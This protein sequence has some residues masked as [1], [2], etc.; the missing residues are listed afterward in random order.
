MKKLKS[1]LAL[2]IAMVIMCI[3]VCSACAV[4]S[5]ED[6]LAAYT[7]LHTLCWESVYDYGVTSSKYGCYFYNAPGEDIPSIESESFYKAQAFLHEAD[8]LLNHSLVGDHTVEEYEEL[9]NKFYEALNSLVLTKGMLNSMIIFCSEE[10][11][12][13]GYYSDE[14]W[15][16]FCEELEEAKAVYADPDN[17]KD[18][19]VTE[20]YFE[21]LHSHFRLCASNT[22]YGDVD[23]D[24]EITVMDATNVQMACAKLRDFNSSQYIIA[25][26]DVTYASEIQRYIASLSANIVREDSKLDTYVDYVDY[27][28]IHSDKFRFKSWKYNYRYIASTTSTPV[29]YPVYLEGWLYP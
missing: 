18:F 21:L 9:Y 19:I 1:I 26:K 10:K 8:D 23:N 5:Q 3:S 20:A 2:M 4:E 6:L 12:D 7:D 29:S 17:S 15:S 16:D 24:S 27:S 25:K 13:N 14:L 11:N 22:M 28:D